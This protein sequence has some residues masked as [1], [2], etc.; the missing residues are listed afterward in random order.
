MLYII[1]LF[2][3]IKNHQANEKL[4]DLTKERKDVPGMIDINVVNDT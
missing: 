4:N 1:Q 2:S 3:V